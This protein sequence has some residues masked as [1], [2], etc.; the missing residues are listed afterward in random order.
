MYFHFPLGGIGNI[1]ANWTLYLLNATDSMGGFLMLEIGFFKCLYIKK[2][3]RMAFLDDYF[4]ATFLGLM[5]MMLAL[6]KSG[7]SMDMGV[8]ENTQTFGVLAGS[9]TN[10]TK[11]NKILAQNCLFW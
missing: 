7:V 5:N 4:F 2:W 11:S 10:I 6:I 1:L 8:Y 3:S 9:Q